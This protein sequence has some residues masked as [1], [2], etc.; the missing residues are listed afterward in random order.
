MSRGRKIAILAYVLWLGAYLFFGARSFYQNFGLHTTIDTRVKS[1]SV[2]SV[3]FG[4]DLRIP[5]VKP[6]HDHPPAKFYVGRKT[7]EIRFGD[8]TYLHEH[9]VAGLTEYDIQIVYLTRTDLELRDT[10]LHE[11]FHVLMCDADSFDK[12]EGEW[13]EHVDPQSN[14]NHRWIL[15]MTPQMLQFFRQNR[16]LVEWLSA[17]ETRQ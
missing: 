4:W 12:F 1:W 7:Y 10:L 17:K 3:D 15:P 16:K 2:P 8:E 13:Q 6:P 11:I 5:L 9:N 14:D